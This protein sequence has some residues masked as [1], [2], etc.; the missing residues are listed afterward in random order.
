M[1]GDL[2]KSASRIVN[3]PSLKGVGFLGGS[4][5]MKVIKKRKLAPLGVN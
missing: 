2:D 1:R 3:Y 4:R 5:I